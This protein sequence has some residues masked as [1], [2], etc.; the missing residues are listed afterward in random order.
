VDIFLNQ[1]VQFYLNNT[2]NL[3]HLTQ[4]RIVTIDSVTS[5]HTMYRRRPIHSVKVRIYTDAKVVELSHLLY[6]IGIVVGL[7][8]LIANQT[9]APVPFEHIMSGSS[10]TADILVLLSVAS[11]TVSC[12]VAWCC[13]NPL[14]LV[15]VLHRLL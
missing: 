8:Y 14:R 4:R 2:T 12:L 3:R 1:L 9:L 13:S 15:S 10:A 5:L 6:M 7:N 11:M